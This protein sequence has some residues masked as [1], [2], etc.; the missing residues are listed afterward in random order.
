MMDGERAFWHDCNPF[1]HQW[2]P[3]IQCV[4]AGMIRL[5]PGS[6]VASAFSIVRLIGSGSMG[7]VYEARV[8]ETGG[9]V[10]LKFPHPAFGSSKS[11][12]QRFHR[13]AHATL[14]IDS[15]H[16]VRTYA[17]VKL[18]RGMPV[19]VMEYVDGT[20]LADLIDRHEGPIPLPLVLLLVKQIAIGL[21]AAHG[22]G[23][24]HR[25]LKPSNVL[26]RNL[27]TAPV[28]KVFD[29]G[30]SVILSEGGSR[31]TFSGSSFGTPQYMAPEQIHDTKHMDE[32]ADIYALG[33]MTYE[34]LTGRWPFSGTTTQEIWHDALNSQPIALRSRR[35]ELSQELCDIVM[36]AMARSKEDR[37][38]TAD[39]FREALLPFF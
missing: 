20:E 15:P 35:P 37:F 33:V 16:V 2:G 10:A 6:I 9:R 30:L 36:R 5:E 38:A 22:A 17:V 7:T 21:S 11:A 19:L 29:F 8:I 34:L 14:A 18:K 25:D 3:G 32:R 39:E 24:I 12:L 4:I 13:E 26:V 27:R 1:T 23:V 28:A 31:L